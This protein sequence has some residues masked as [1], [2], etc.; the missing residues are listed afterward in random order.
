MVPPHF[1]YT[2]LQTI[3]YEMDPFPS[4]SRRALV[5]PEGLMYG[6]ARM[7]QMVQ[8]DDNIYVF[9]VRDEALTWLGLEKGG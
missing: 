4:T 5:A 2:D 1:L 7:Y 3:A 9:Q 6:I 8:G